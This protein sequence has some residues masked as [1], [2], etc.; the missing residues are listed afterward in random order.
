MPLDEMRVLLLTLLGLPLAAA[1]VVAALGPRNGPAVRWVSLAAVLVNLLLT[2]VLAVRGSEVL[3]KRADAE[4]LRSILV[5][6]LKA[7]DGANAASSNQPLTF[8]PEYV[9]GAT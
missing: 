1:V 3:K 4:A 6:P 5:S 7:A 8:L 2:G 9:P